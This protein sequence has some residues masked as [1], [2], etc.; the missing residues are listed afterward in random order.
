MICFFENYRGRL[1]QPA[2][3][4]KQGAAF[5]QTAGLGQAIAY[6]R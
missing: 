2:T 5:I 1:A 3:R 4:C 6:R